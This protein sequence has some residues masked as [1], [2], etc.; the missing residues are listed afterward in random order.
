MLQ[1]VPRRLTIAMMSCYYVARKKKC[2]LRFD[3]KQQ[4]FRASTPS[5]Y[6]V[7]D[8]RISLWPFAPTRPSMVVVR[9]SLR[10]CDVPAECRKAEMAVATTLRVSGR[11]VQARGPVWRHPSTRPWPVSYTV[12]GKWAKWTVQTTWTLLR[13][14]VAI[15]VITTNIV[16][17]I[18]M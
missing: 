2:P 3:Y 13:N 1:C 6:L 12:S 4:P 8:S 9:C 7:Y 16:F 14:A 5:I 18:I 11:V 10:I 15:F 17:L